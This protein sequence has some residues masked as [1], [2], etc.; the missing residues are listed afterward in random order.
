M[1][2]Q[3]K[4]I[5]PRIYGLGNQPL[6][7]TLRLRLA[8]QKLSTKMW[9]QVLSFKAPDTLTFMNYGYTPK[10]PKKNPLML[11]S[12]DEPNRDTIQLYRRVAGAVPLRGKDVLEVGS[13]RGGGAAFVTKYLGPRS[14][15]GIDFCGRA[16]AFCNRTHL[17]EGLSFIQ[18][19]AE[20]LP[21]ASGSFD[22][23]LNLESC[24]CYVSVE[25]FF[26]E[27]VRVLR[28]GGDF[29]FADVGPM[30]YIEAVREELER[31]GLS[32]LEQEDITSNVTEALEQNTQRHRASIQKEVPVG[33]RAIF[34][35]FAGL[36]GTPVFDAIRSGSW[37]Y[38]R[39]VLRKP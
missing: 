5:Y 35:N 25:R 16:V 1:L 14:M 24:H 4:T 21:F 17:V 7:P 18:G 11:D 10:D 28:P 3:D 27:V 19:D 15:V 9:Y 29:L 6:P 33:L 23:V 36:K 34:R 37:E 38:V 26:A 30:P 2:Y 8:L 22:A 39:Y 12:V 31:C 13:G 20:Q 32:I